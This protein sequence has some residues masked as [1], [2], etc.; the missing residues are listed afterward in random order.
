MKK[1]T[2]KTVRSGFGGA[3][4]LQGAITTAVCMASA[5]QDVLSQRQLR[6][7]AD[8]LAVEEEE[9]QVKRL[10]LAR[11][12]QQLEASTSILR[13]NVGGQTFDTTRETL[14]SSGSTYFR[15][16]LDSTGLV[17]GAMRDSEGRLFID[18]SPEGFRHCLEW[19]RGSAEVHRLNQAERETL[20]K[21]AV[22]YDL[23]K[24]CQE[25][26]LHCGDYE[27]RGEYDPNVLPPEEQDARAQAQII[28]KALGQGQENAAAN[29]EAALI[30]V[31][32]TQRD[33][34]SERTLVYTGEEMFKGAPILFGAEAARHRT[35]LKGMACQ[36][37]AG[38][39][40]RL[41]LFA[42]PLFRGLDMTNLVVAGGAVLEALTLKHV[43]GDT[44]LRDESVREQAQQGTADIDVFI[45][46]DDEQTA[47]AAFDRVFAHLKHNL[48]QTEHHQLLVLRSPMAVSFYAAFPNR[49]IQVVL[50]R[51]ACVADVIFNF[52][53]DACQLAY[54][55][56]RVVG[57]HA[58]FRAF[59]TG[60]NI[61]DPER[62][63]PTYEKRL[64]KYSLRG[65]AVVVPGLEMERVSDRFKSGCFTWV[66]HAL[67][68]VLLTFGG[69]DVPTYSI[70]ER[71]IVG[72]P[73]LLVLSSVR[74]L[75][76][77]KWVG[78][79]DNGNLGP[80]QAN[81]LTHGW[82]DPLSAQGAYLLKLD[83]LVEYCARSGEGRGNLCK[84][85]RAPTPPA[86][87]PAMVMENGPSENRRVSHGSAAPCHATCLHR[88]LEC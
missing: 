36:D 16:L 9:L 37:M 84:V 40:A 14:L 39:R 81:I 29:A 63:S 54:D 52:D 25:L 30:S 83:R 18:R 45:V 88:D 15:H 48:D 71:P 23:A 50:R 17:A 74:T 12:R 19:L 35:V 38:F 67:R 58:A 1:L 61:A 86:R 13:L 56:Q 24:L 41:D 34:R 51:Y 87:P 44:G 75:P 73:K 57:T 80:L 66:Q 77:P 7:E 68:R 47:R 28:R 64:A 60:L 5:S 22:Y 31:F 69:G 78:H 53:V 65:F 33:G 46:A 4:V 3:A 62:S 32:T 42:G 55:G 11:E 76:R 59:R 49:T 21:E 2:L 20:L 82:E 72:L 27:H 70:D 43:L 10:K 79:G 26:Q 6:L 8:R 85:W